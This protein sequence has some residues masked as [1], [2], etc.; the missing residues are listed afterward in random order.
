MFSVSERIRPPT[1]QLQ[2]RSAPTPGM[3]IPTNRDIGITEEE[4]K[5]RSCL[6]PLEATTPVSA[7]KALRCSRP[8]AVPLLAASP[9]A[10]L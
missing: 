7:L 9:A 10:S 3:G 1:M 5:G 6:F 2:R 8:E 4:K